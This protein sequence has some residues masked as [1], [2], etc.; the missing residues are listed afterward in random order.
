M[1]VAVL[2]GLNRLVAEGNAGPVVR[3]EQVFINIRSDDL[4]YCLKWDG[5]IEDEEIGEFLDRAGKESG[6]GQEV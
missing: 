3:Q 4:L 6:E 2:Q 5:C 1:V